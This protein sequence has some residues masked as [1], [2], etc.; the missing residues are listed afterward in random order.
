ML[1]GRSFE[2]KSALMGMCAVDVSRVVRTDVPRGSPSSSTSN[3]GFTTEPCMGTSN[4]K[5]NFIDTDRT[6][7]L[8]GPGTIGC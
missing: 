8:L 5:A 1:L 4:V 2:G 6:N 7:D 3:R